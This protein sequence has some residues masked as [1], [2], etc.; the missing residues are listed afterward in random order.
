M[1]NFLLGSRPEH[2]MHLK[3]PIML[4]KSF[5]YYA[6]ILLKCSPL[7]PKYALAK[8]YFDCSIRVSGILMDN[9]I[10]FCG[11]CYIRVSLT[12]TTN[13]TFMLNQSVTAIL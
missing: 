8:L 3:L 6:P 5:S 12:L 10:T 4:L 9:I 2:V 7:C 11:D 1:Q 13:T